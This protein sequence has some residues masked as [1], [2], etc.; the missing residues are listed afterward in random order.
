MLFIDSGLKLLDILPGGTI[1]FEIME[2]VEKSE[3]E[4]AMTYFVLLNK[5]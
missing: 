2:F 3:L 4:N 5:I 1:D